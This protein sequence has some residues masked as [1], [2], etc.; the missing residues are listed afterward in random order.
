MKVPLRNEK[1]SR[2]AMLKLP[3]CLILDHRIEAKKGERQI[4]SMEATDPTK[5]LKGQIRQLGDKRELWMEC[6][7]CSLMINVKRKVNV[8]E[9]PRVQVNRTK[10]T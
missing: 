4:I 1:R 10:R 8:I 2:A 3:I 9:Q 6:F 7:R 5:D